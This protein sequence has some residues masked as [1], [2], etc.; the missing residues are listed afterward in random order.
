MKKSEMY[1][2][3]QMAV[4]RD[5]GMSSLDKLE[6]LRELMDREDIEKYMEDMEATKGDSK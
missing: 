3:A 4:M 1:K 2:Y 5:Q 6:I